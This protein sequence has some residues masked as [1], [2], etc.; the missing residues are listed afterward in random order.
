MQSQPSLCMI[1][2]II[3]A[4]RLQKLCDILHPPHAKIT[5]WLGDPSRNCKDGASRKNDISRPL[6]LLV[7]YFAL[8]SI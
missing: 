7:C 1:L 2:A 5:T 4:W 6:M 8:T 3:F